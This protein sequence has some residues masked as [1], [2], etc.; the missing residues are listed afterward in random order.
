VCAGS[1]LLMANKSNPA[2]LP[3]I[4]LLV[5]Q[6]CYEAVSACVEREES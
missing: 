4:N 6:L 3:R 2:H 1:V 5:V